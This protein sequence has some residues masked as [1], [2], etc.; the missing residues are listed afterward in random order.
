MYSIPFFMYAVHQDVYKVILIETSFCNVYFN[1]AKNCHNSYMPYD[2]IITILLYSIRM[3]TNIKTHTARGK[4]NV[5][6]PH[7]LVI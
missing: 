7:L 4:N 2:V 1:A 5:C 6:I 3:Y